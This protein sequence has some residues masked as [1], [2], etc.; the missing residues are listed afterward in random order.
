MKYDVVD[1]CGE[2]V[3]EE[4]FVFDFATQKQANGAVRK[5]D[6]EWEGKG[7]EKTTILLK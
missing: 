2:C 5:S 6:V 3:E 4:G 1:K 7:K